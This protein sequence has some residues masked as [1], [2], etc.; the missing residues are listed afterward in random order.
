[1]SGRRK[2]NG[3][4]SI[5]QRSSDGRWVGAI[6]I[7]YD[8]KGRPIR[9]T[10]SAR[11]GDEVRR[12]MR[13]VQ[14]HLDDGLPPPD[15][16]MTIKHLLQRWEQDVLRHRVARTAFDNYKSLADHHIEPTL[17]RKRVSKLTPADVDALVSAK[18]DSGLSAS[19]VGRI[20][21]VLSQALD[22]AVRWGVVTRNVVTMTKGPKGKRKE[23]R[24][25]DPSQAKRLLAAAKGHRMESLYVTMLYTGT[26]PGEALGLTWNAVDLSVGILVVQRALKREGT[27]LVLGDVKTASSRRSVNLAGPVVE[28]LRQHRKRQAQDRLAAG[29][30]WTDL[31]LVFSTEVGTPIDPS[32]L[33]RDL[34]ATCE[35][36]GLGHWHPHELRHSAASLMLGQEVPLEVVADVLGHSSIRMTADVYGH[37]RAPQ[38]QRAAEAMTDALA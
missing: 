34:T 28:S 1:M 9:K 32:N 10:V 8:E 37:I 36:A 31:D 7:G 17:G 16:R 5:Y 24:G 35:R 18:L 33:R 6:S 22:Q 23:G 30:S 38:R 3:E 26:R 21:S 25:L 12:K 13:T 19:T 14:R 11:T 15:D 20:R 29:S 27:K 2:L 4:G